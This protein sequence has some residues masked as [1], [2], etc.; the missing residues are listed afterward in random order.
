[1]LKIFSCQ[2]KS[3]TLEVG[4]ILFDKIAF[5]KL[6][7]KVFRMKTVSQSPKQCKWFI[8]RFS[9][10]FV[11]E[12][13][14]KPHFFLLNHRTLFTAVSLWNKREKNPTFG[15]WI[16]ISRFRVNYWNCARN[17][18]RMQKEQIHCLNVVIENDFNLRWNQV[19]KN[20]A[21]KNALLKLRSAINQD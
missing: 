16:S 20:E 12:L 9:F 5:E 7:Q 4:E 17:P 13:R 19:V 6:F 10:L 2:R 15:R 14:A 3:D 18:K 8:R 11:V 1:M 21:V